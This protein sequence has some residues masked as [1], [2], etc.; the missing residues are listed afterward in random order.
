MS[1]IKCDNCGL[2]NF[3]DVENCKR[4]KQSLHEP[5]GAWRD[6]RWLVK[7][8]SVPLKGQCIKCNDTASVSYKS[9]SVKAYS[10]WSLLTQIMG[11]RIFHMIPVDVPLCSKHRDPLDKVSISI[12]IAGVIIGLAGVPLMRMNSL[13]PIILFVG[14]IFLVVPTGLV[15]FF[16]RREVVKVWRFKDPYIW[17]WG[18]DRSF[19]DGLPNWSEKKAR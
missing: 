9:V 15:L 5:V 8:L 3:S 18:V 1:S 13:L 17:L 16:Q 2:V 19:L 11:V 12:M 7:K 4:C 10:A 6:R 14:G